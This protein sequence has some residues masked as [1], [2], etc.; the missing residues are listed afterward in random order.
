MLFLVLLFVVRN[1]IVCVHGFILFFLMLFIYINLTFYAL[2]FI[3]SH[4]DKQC[5]TLLSPEEIDIIVADVISNNQNINNNN[6][7]NSNKKVSVKMAI[8]DLKVYG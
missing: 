2:Q 1:V 3:G 5:I 4:H 7:D 6:D 8:E